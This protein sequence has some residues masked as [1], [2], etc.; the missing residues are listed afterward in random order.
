MAGASGPLL[1]VLLIGLFLVFGVPLAFAT[2]TWLQRKQR[3]RLERSKRPVEIQAGRDVAP[4]QSH[5]ECQHRR[6]RSK[7][8]EAP[9][10]VIFSVCKWCGQP[11]KRNGPDDWVAIAPPVT[12]K[13]HGTPL[14]DGG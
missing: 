4:E 13:L 7:A 5:R 14:S 1:W 10:G 2:Y 11:M 3:R 8:R 6:S 12:E 9:D